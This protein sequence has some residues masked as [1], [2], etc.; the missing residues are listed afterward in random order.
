MD[1]LLEILGS[2]DEDSREAAA[3]ALGT[4]GAAA[5]EP[6]TRMLAAGDADQRWWAARALAEIGGSQAVSL[7]A[8]V[9]ADANADVRACAALALGQIGDEAAAG[10][11]ATCLTDDSAFVASIASDALAMMGEAAVAALVDMLSDARP[12][13]RLL[14]IRAL[15]RIQ[16]PQAIGPLFEMLDD[17]SYLVQ[18]HAREALEALG[19]GMVFF[20]PS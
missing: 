13:T 16:S 20:A 8:G 17:P 18:F 15:E 3:I 7:L 12:H 6:L 5:I 14:A 2:S 1:R 11:L 9:L 19:A 4:Y 10:A